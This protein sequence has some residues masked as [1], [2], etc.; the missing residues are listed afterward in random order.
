MPAAWRKTSYDEIADG[1]KG[2]NVCRCFNECRRV[3][4]EMRER[5]P[6]DVLPMWGAIKFPP[7][8]ADNEQHRGQPEKQHDSPSGIDHE[9]RMVP[10]PTQEALTR[11]AKSLHF[12]YN[13]VPNRW[14]YAPPRYIFQQYWFAWDSSS[15]F[16]Q[17]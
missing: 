17:Q 2:E 16:S 12:D 10:K 4:T 1:D 5:N 13:P 3:E 14:F 11:L 8:Q 6:L 9:A 15:N 7:R